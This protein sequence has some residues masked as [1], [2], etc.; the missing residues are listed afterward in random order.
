MTNRVDGSILI[1]NASTEKFEATND[2]EKQTINGGS[3]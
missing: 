1:Y 2:L 3:F